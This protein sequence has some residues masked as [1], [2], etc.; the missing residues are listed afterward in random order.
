LS[1]IANRDNHTSLHGHQIGLDV[2]LENDSGPL[3]CIPAGKEARL[4][5]KQ[6]LDRLL[7]LSASGTSKKPD[8]PVKLI[9]RPLIFV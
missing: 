1:Q 5:S 4:C 8:N 2:C 6:H 9:S 3:A 7:K